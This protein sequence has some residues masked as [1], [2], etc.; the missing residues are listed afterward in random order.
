[1]TAPIKASNASQVIGLSSPLAIIGAFVEIIRIRFTES[2]VLDPSLPW[3]WVA[4]AP[5]R[6]AEQDTGIFIESAWNED[7]PEE[8]TRPGIWVDIDDH[9]YRK[10]SVGDQDQISES[11][12]QRMKLF[13]AKAE[14]TMSIHCTSPERGV[15]AMV[16]SVVQDFL[17]C[18]SHDIKKC[19]GYHDISPIVMAKPQMMEKD[20][21]LFDTLLNY[22]VAYEMRWQSAPITHLINRI[23]ATVADRDG[24]GGNTRTI[25]TRTPVT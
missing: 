16:A 18:T 21:R 4:E 24:V 23:H 8:N 9:V 1:M 22:R 6:T 20:R 5:G 3:Y 25:T 10:V 7:I 13:Y 19:Y 14:A 11:L 17:T 2:N 12:R 15:S